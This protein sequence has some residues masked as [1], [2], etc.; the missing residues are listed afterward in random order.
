ME[1][2][3]RYFLQASKQLDSNWELLKQGLPGV[4]SWQEWAVRE[5]SADGANIGFDPKLIT[6]GE[7]QSLETL[8]NEKGIDNCK[9]VAIEENLIDEIWGSD[10]P[11]RSKAPV[12]V[13]PIEYSGKTSQDKIKELK[14]GLRKSN[15]HGL[16]VTALDDVAWLF[17]LRGQD[18]TYNPVF[19]AYAV[20]YAAEVEHT[21]LYIDGQKVNEK[22][23]EHLGEEVKIK[24]YTDIF[25]DARDLGSTLVSMNSLKPSHQKIKLQVPDTVSWGL[26]KAF[27]GENNVIFVKSPVEL[28]KAIKN[29]VE[30]ANAKDTQIKDSVA[31]IRFFAWL[32]KQLNDGV[33][34]T[35]YEAGLKS[36][37]FREMNDT[38]RGLSFTTIAASGPSASVIHYSPPKDSKEMVKRDQVFLLD[39]GG[40]YLGGTTDTTRTLH[41]GKPSAEEIKAYTLVLKGHIA[42]AQMIFPDGTNG[43]SLDCVARQHLWKYG[44]DYRHGTSHGVGSYLNVHEGTLGI[45]FRIKFRNSPLHAG[46]VMSNEPGYYDDGK[47]GIRI[48]NVVAVKNVQTEHQ[49]SGQFLGIETITMVPM[50]TKLIDTKMLTVDEIKWLNQYHQDVYKATRKYLKRPEDEW[51]LEWLERETRPTF[52]L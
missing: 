29:P 34:I 10:R 47:Y 36:L 14:A 28:A 52:Q 46:H 2:D 13:L 33:E 15:A 42:L 43:Y 20:V 21:I 51:A 22:V 18:I 23:T 7:V 26:V 16:V 19:F 3:G 9:V 6:Y 48:E 41:F 40:Q 27:G 35:D 45:G 44:L 17:N 32:E 5:A 8:V 4:P 30:L 11:S 38:F 50:C 31:L 12:T 37:E 49:F 39:S 24:P 1:T 25:S